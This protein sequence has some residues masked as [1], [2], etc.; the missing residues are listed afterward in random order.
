MNC[1]AIILFYFCVLTCNYAFFALFCVPM[2]IL[3]PVGSQTLHSVPLILVAAGPYPGGGGRT[4]RTTPPQLHKGTLFQ[5][6]NTSWTVCCLWGINS[7]STNTR[8]VRSAALTTR[9]S[10]FLYSM[11]YS[12]MLVIKHHFK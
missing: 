7:R 5:A 9:G 1:A 10:W 3:Q 6:A 8:L 4:G 2:V 11:L 12:L